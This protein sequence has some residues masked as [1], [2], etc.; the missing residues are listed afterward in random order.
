[1]MFLNS[2]LRSL[3]NSSKN[4]TTPFPSKYFAKIIDIFVLLKLI[5]MMKSL[6]LHEKKVIFH[7]DF[8]CEALVLLRWDSLGSKI[9]FP[10]FESSEGS[11]LSPTEKF[12]K[13]NMIEEPSLR[14]FS[15]Q[16]FTDKG[17][18]YFSVWF[19]SQIRS[20]IGPSRS[21]QIFS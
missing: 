15:F 18:L 11:T 5:A 20:Q 21:L 8:S 2:Q 10:K 19:S 9:S 3:K 4:T 7:K 13:E 16:F 17:F 12:S 1:M 6:K 14:D